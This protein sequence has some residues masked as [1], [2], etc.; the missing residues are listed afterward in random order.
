[1]ARESS[2]SVTTGEVF[3][4][5]D[6]VLQPTIDQLGFQINSLS[7]YNTALGFDLGLFAGAPAMRFSTPS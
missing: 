3:G 2:R 7:L 1:M 4:I 6:A 5:H